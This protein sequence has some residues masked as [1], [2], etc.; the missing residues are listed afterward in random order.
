MCNCT[1]N[2]NQIRQ[3]QQTRES[4]IVSRGTNQISIDQQRQLQAQQQQ[5][6]QRQANQNGVTRIRN[7]YR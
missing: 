6:Q 2:N 1:K 3:A 4:P 5:S 7:T